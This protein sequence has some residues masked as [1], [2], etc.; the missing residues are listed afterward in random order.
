MEVVVIHGVSSY[1]PKPDC[2]YP[3]SV[4]FGFRTV[5]NFAAKGEVS[6]FGLHFVKLN[7]LE[8][9]HLVVVVALGS[10]AIELKVEWRAAVHTPAS[11][12]GFKFR[13][14]CSDLE[15]SGAGHKLKY[16]KR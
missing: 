2:H 10:Y 1:L 13:D 5:A 16:V 15:G 6:S 7:P 11:K 4:V 8:R 9:P 14:A 3:V 12:L